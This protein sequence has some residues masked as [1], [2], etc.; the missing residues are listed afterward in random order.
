MFHNVLLRACPKPCSKRADTML[1]YY[2]HMKE[3]HFKMF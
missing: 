3:E 1:H 2:F